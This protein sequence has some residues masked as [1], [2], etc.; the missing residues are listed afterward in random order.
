V[1]FKSTERAQAEDVTRSQLH[2]YAAGYRQLTG[3]APDLVEVMNLNLQGVN[4]R[5]E[6]DESI[7][8][9]IVVRIKDAGEAIRDNDLPRLATWESTCERC[10][11][12]GIC[13]DTP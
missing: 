7:L 12:S 10:D 5:E 9:D 8:E 3:S 6:V 13:R 4:T 11:L 1:D 2:V